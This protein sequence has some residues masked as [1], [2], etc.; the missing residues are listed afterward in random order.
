MNKGKKVATRNDKNSND[1]VMNSEKSSLGKSKPTN[2]LFEKSGVGNRKNPPISPKIIEI[3]AVL[4]S[5]F[6]SKKL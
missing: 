6:L 1:W 2:K 4:S 5:I 3:Y